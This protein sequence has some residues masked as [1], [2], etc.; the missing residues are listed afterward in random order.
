MPADASDHNVIYVNE[1]LSYPEFS[2]QIQ[3]PVTALPGTTAD[4]QQAPDQNHVPAAN[5]DSLDLQLESM[6][7]YENSP[8]A[9]QSSV[10]AREKVVTSAI[11]NSATRRNLNL[12]KED[13]NKKVIVTKTTRL[14]PALSAI[15]GAVAEAGGLKNTAIGKAIE[16]I[17]ETLG[18]VVNPL[19]KPL[20]E[21]ANEQLRSTPAGVSSREY[22]LR[23]ILLGESVREESFKLGFDEEYTYDCPEKPEI[24]AFLNGD[25][26]TLPVA[27][28]VQDELM[29]SLD[30]TLEVPG[31]LEGFRLITM[32]QIINTLINRLSEK[33]APNDEQ[34]KLLKDF[35]SAPEE[36]KLQLVKFDG[37][38][39]PDVYAIGEGNNKILVSA[40]RKKLF[41]YTVGNESLKVITTRDSALLDFLKEDAS[42]IDSGAFV[43]SSSKNTL[44]GVGAESL[45]LSGESPFGTYN[46]EDEKIRAEAPDKDIF[47]TQYAAGINKIKEDFNGQIFTGDEAKDLKRRQQIQALSEVATIAITAATLPVG[48]EAGAGFTALT[49]ALGLSASLVD[50]YESEQEANEA[51]RS[52]A[53]EAALEAAR[54]GYLYLSLYLLSPGIFS[55]IKGA[56]TVE[57]LD[58]AVVGIENEA[59]GF[60]QAVSEG[61]TS[62]GALQTAAPPTELDASLITSKNLEGLQPGTGNF[63]GTYK[64]MDNGFASYY[65]QQDGKVYELL[66]DKTSNIWKVRRPGQPRFGGYHVPVR[67]D[68]ATSK[69]IR[70]TDNPGLAGGGWGR[71]GRRS[72]SQSPGN[73]ITDYSTDRSVSGR[74]SGG[75]SSPVSSSGG[76][77]SPVSS[78]KVSSSPVSSSAS[79]MSSSGTSTRTINRNS[80]EDRLSRLGGT[81]V[82]TNTSRAQGTVRA[83][84]RY[85]PIRYETNLGTL[86]NGPISRDSNVL[87]TGILREDRVVD[88]HTQTVSFGMARGKITT[89]IA[90]LDETGKAVINTI[91]GR[92]RKT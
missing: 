5:T 68:V 46:P 77:S 81:S 59:T 26:K 88:P 3:D 71:L 21:A 16:I 40:K 22:A 89:G 27:T 65:A 83:K 49:T 87:R 52:S 53:R 67:Y 8:R 31:V 60:N 38:V 84:N 58:A 39:V 64:I 12:T 57:E 50:I 11:L 80:H 1:A 82:R 63:T 78:S 62:R 20:K 9:T 19:E 29:A 55:A 91:W 10:P 25:N 30:K 17:G 13:L 15:G 24:N 4:D 70:R 6:E 41:F 75:D 47:K 54:T 48:G 69:W 23:D 76:S 66:Y 56:A 43:R 74:S 14:K 90:G 32:G 2:W 18:L 61:T 51:D 86:T 72:N 44:I 33:P 34:L 42:E 7:A 35:L 45:T 28:D 92:N 37:K 73:S 79:T 36:K 85:K